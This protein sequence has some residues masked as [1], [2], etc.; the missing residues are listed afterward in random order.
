M[1]IFFTQAPEHDGGICSP[2]QMRLFVKTSSGVTAAIEI[3]PCDTILTLKSKLYREDYDGLPSYQRL[4]F[5]GRTLNDDYLTFEELNI[6]RES[7]LHSIASARGRVAVLPDAMG[8][9]PKRHEVVSGDGLPWYK[10]VV[11]GLTVTWTCSCGCEFNKHHGHCLLTI[12]HCQA[13]KRCPKCKDPSFTLTAFRFHSCK[14]RLLVNSGDN[15]EPDCT[16]VIVGDHECVTYDRD[17]IQFE[18]L[19]ILASPL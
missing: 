1:V 13:P 14:A 11:K 15:N 2:N 17:S 3:N 5:A 18:K 10:L 8:D 16:T 4:S 19:R 9:D 12:D 6:Q 7:T